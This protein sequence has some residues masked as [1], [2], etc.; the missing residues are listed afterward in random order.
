MENETSD[1]IRKGGLL[2]FGNWLYL[3]YAIKKKKSFAFK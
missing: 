3:E 2:H 1:K